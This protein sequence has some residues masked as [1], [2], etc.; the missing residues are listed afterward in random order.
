MSSEPATSSAPK[1]PKFRHLEQLSMAI[2]CVLV[3]GC[4]CI[5][6]DGFATI[7]NATGMLLTMSIVGMLCC[8]MLF[9]LASGDFDLSIGSVVA[10][11]GV[12]AVCVANAQHSV[13]LGV[14]AGVGVG[15]LIG[16]LNGSVVAYLKI[17]PLITTLATMQAARGLAYIAGDGKTVTAS[18]DFAKLGGSLSIPWGS[19]H[20]SIGY[21]VL[22]MLALLVIF[23]VVL[24]YSVFGRSVLALGGNEEAA[25]LA[26]IPVKRT[27][28]MVFVL[29]GLVAG[30]AGVLLAAR[31]QT[32]DPK[33]EVGLELK[34]ISACV[35]GGVAL[36]GGRGS[37]FAVIWGMLIMGTVQRAMDLQQI[38]IYWQFLITGSIL[39]AAVIIDR[40][41][42]KLG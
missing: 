37:I 15:G 16:L 9:C 2:V 33:A 4:A 24:H 3:M 36:T 18:E 40:F 29:Q 1:R 30:L 5:F 20:I 14:C 28:L 10:L 6:V 13:V 11:A 42:S 38:G 17:N 41:K 26:G 21:S 25:R 27:R 31:L 7:G 8:T 22:V 39:L 34:V 12:S 23:G 19:G 32:G 35:L